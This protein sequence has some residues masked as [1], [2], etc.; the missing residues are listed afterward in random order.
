MRAV[1]TIRGTQLATQEQGI[2]EP[3]STAQNQWN[4]LFSLFFLFCS[5]HLDGE[6]EALFLPIPFFFFCQTISGLDQELYS[7]IWPVLYSWNPNHSEL[8]V[9]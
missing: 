9:G 7:G 2:P 8:G 1:A 5:V 3:L 6:D 4:I